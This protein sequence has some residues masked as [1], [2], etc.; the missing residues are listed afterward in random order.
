MNTQE[1][2]SILRYAFSDWHIRGICF[3]SYCALGRRGIEI[4]KLTIDDLVAVVEIDSIGA[5]NTKDILVLQKLIY[6]MAEWCNFDWCFS[7]RYMII[8]RRKNK[9]PLGIGEIFNFKTIGR[10]LENYV[11]YR[12]KNQIFAKIYFIFAVLPR[13]L[14]LRGLGTLMHLIK[15]IIAAKFFSA[16]TQ[17]SFKSRFL[18][19]DFESPCDRFTFDLDKICNTKVIGEDLKV[20]SSFYMASLEKERFFQHTA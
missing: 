16:L 8:Y 13:I 15:V 4:K 2:S 14:T 20:H 1:I 12:K 19:I 6:I 17:S 11:R 10:R 7:H 3:R 5:I 9:R 18:I